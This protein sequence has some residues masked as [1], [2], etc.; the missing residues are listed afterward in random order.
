MNMEGNHTC[1]TIGMPPVGDITISF[2]AVDDEQE[3]AS[4]PE[5]ASGAPA[6]VCDAGFNGNLTFDQDE[7][8]SGTCVVTEEVDNEASNETESDLLE[9]NLTEEDLEE[10]QDEGVLPGFNLLVAISVL[11]IVGVIRRRTH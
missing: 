4:C 2:K 6:C 8:W 11:G 9:T 5:N 1:S 3:L 7:G 10:L